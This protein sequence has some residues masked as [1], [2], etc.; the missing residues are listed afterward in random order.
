MN[1]R[2]KIITR[3]ANE[4]AIPKEGDY[5]KPDGWPVY[6]G[7]KLVKSDGF[8]DSEFPGSEWTIT[9]DKGN[10]S[11]VNIRVTGRPHYDDG[12]QKSRVKIEWVQDGGEPSKF[13]GGWL[14]DNE[15]TMEMGKLNLQPLSSFNTDTAQASLD[16]IKSSLNATV[17]G[18]RVYE[19]GGPDHVAIG[20]SFSIDPRE[21]W[22]N[23]I[24]ENSR[25]AQFMLENDGT[26][27]HL[28]G[29]GIGRMRLTRT[30]SVDD[31]IDKLNA[32]I[33]KAPTPL[34]GEAHMNYRKKITAK[35][36]KKAE[37]KMG[38]RYKDIG[39]GSRIEGPDGE[40]QLSGV[41]LKV[42]KVPNADERGL[43]VDE[44]DPQGANRRVSEIEL[45]DLIRRSI[46]E[47]IERRKF[48]ERDLEPEN[49][50]RLLKKYKIVFR[51]DPNSPATTEETYTATDEE[52]VV[53][54]IRSMW[55]EGKD[56]VIEDISVIDE[57]PY[58]TQ[59][60]KQKA[61]NAHL[62]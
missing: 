29:K 2:D 52:Q 22:S 60:D 40:P 54:Y 12:K 1:Y 6:D 39:N 15:E 47:K 53:N 44:R 30:K 18:G 45:E 61:D 49:Y 33:S 17:T 7:A 50:N 36:N 59:L 26:L 23:G 42:V 21:E 11:A 27:K 41:V 10:R 19:L 4:I 38:D 31:V 5:L 16:K 32:F 43:L 62:N 56:I 51:K 28:A 25:Y 9:S 55:S 34:Q 48:T 8:S 46:L 14:I 20:I 35:L 24:F 57:H 13:G 37:M 3:L 58:Q